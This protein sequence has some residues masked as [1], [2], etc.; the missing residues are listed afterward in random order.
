ML[1]GVVAALAAWDLNPFV[2]RLRSVD[3]VG[4]QAE[5]RQGL[6]RSHLRRL[7]LVCS[8]GSALAVVALGSRVKLG[9]GAAFWLGLLA[10]LGL[11]RA[12][13]FLRSESAQ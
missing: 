2:Q 13:G 3:G 7:L 5:R 4:A 1:S 8:L 9:F 6:E 10:V 12:I 11:S